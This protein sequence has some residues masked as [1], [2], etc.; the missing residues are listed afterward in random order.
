MKAVIKKVATGV[1]SEKHGVT[2]IVN[3]ITLMNDTVIVRDEKQ[4]SADLK[5]SH[6][7]PRQIKHLKGGIVEGDFKFH[8]KGDKYIAN[9]FNTKGVE[10]GTEL[11]YESDGYRVEGFLD[12]ELNEKALEREENATAYAELK[13]GVL[14]FNETISDNSN[15]DSSIEA[16]KA[17]LEALKAS[18]NV[19]IGAED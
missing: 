1:K 9:E 7:K 13:V 6:L 12:L 2:R 16:M 17:E 5:G 3:L 14:G 4:F 19:K 8:K 10:A 18:A 15:D 11:V